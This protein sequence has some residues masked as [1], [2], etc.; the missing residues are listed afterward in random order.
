MDIKTAEGTFTIDST[1]NT[2][3]CDISLKIPQQVIYLR[4]YRVEFDT[5]ANALAT[6]II[7]VDVPWLSGNQLLDTNPGYTYL[8]ILLDNAV[9]SFTFGKSIPVYLSSDIP[10]SFPIRF[11]DTNFQPVANLVRVTLQF[12]LNRGSLV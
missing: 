12:S 9:V 7:Y 3:I 11:L 4:S 10:Q 5:Q 6:Q 8:P 1:T 2:Q